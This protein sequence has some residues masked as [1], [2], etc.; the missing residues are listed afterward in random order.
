MSDLISRSAL[1]EKMIKRFKE[2]DRGRAWRNEHMPIHDAIRLDEI[3]NLQSIAL[4]IEPVDAVPVVHAR[5][6][7]AHGMM[8]PEYH[9]RKQC[10]MCGGWALQDYFGRERMS[11]YCPNCGAKM[12]NNVTN[13]PANPE[14]CRYYTENS[15]WGGGCLGT[16][17][18]DVCQGENCERWKPKMDAKEEE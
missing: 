5:W 13:D 15:F 6:V 2:I 9:H 16:K 3:E 10:S 14:N 7:K 4:D 1:V 11:H 17:E 18:I 8:P 12:L